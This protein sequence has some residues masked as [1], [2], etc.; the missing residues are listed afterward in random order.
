MRTSEEMIEALPPNYDSARR[1]VTWT[2]K[3]W[4]VE[5]TMEVAAIMERWQKLYPNNVLDWNLDGFL[6]GSMQLRACVQWRDSWKVNARVRGITAVLIRK[7]GPTDSLE[8]EY[9]RRQGGSG[10][11]GN[12]AEH[13]GRA[14]EPDHAG[15]QG[16]PGANG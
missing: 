3:Q 8:T 14:N 12:S 15:G 13:S 6:L 1:L 5:K 9:I 7:I 2:W 4:P 10:N 16:H 11:N